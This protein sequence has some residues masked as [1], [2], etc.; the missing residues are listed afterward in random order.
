MIRPTVLVV[1]DEPDIRLLAQT[2]LAADYEV[3]EA[4][5]GIA[6]LEILAARADIAA[7]LLDIRM[8]DMDGFG[9]LTRLA[10]RGV[11]NDL[12]VVMFTAFSE[13]EMVDHA[14]K[15]GAHGVLGKPFTAEELRD[16][17]AAATSGAR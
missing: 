12:R 9:V 17:L 3:L 1:D 13:P 16:V 2:L 6:A 15:L 5:G 4:S 11:L 14:F 8:P 7:V 10:E